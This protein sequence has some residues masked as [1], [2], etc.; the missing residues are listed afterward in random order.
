MRFREL[1]S[2]NAMKTCH[3]NVVI[4]EAEETAAEDP[5]KHLTSLRR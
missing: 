3:S 4:C 5:G 1:P 2:E